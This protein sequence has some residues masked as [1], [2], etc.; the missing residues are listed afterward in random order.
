LVYKPNSVLFQAPVIYLD[1]LLPIYSSCLPS[2]IEHATLIAGLHGIA[3]HRVYLISLQH[4]LYILSVALFLI[5][6]SAAINHYD[7][8]WCSDFPLYNIATRQP[9]YSA[10]ILILFKKQYFNNYYT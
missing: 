3:P 7:A 10:K 6:Q 9:T 5:S 2:N 4:Y 8:L 1:K